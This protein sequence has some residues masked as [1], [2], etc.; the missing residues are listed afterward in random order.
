M[1]QTS[2][3]I[4][5]MLDAQDRRARAEE[6]FIQAAAE[7]QVALVNLQ[8]SKGKLLSYEGIHIVRDRD[9]NNLPLLYLEKG[10]RD[11]KS[12]SDG[13]KSLPNR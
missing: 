8:R 2:D 4:D 10:G 1:S 5:R 7:Y 3:Y 12:V 13:K 6:E 9:E 11:G